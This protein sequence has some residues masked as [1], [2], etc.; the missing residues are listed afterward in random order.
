MGWDFDI[1]VADVEFP[2]Y[3]PYL[4]VKLVIGE[5]GP[6]VKDN[7]ASLDRIDSSMGYVKGNVEVI[8]ILANRIKSNAKPEDIM[9]VAVRLV[10]R[11]GA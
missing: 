7:N 2:D 10:E 5:G 1:K 8:S 9:K 3:C 11:H 4:D 6:A